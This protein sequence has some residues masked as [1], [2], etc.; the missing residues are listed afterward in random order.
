MVELHSFKSR[1]IIALDPP[2]EISDGLGWALRIVDKTK[3][4]V[5]GYELGLPM[6]IR[7]GGLNNLSKLLDSM[8]DEKLKIADI[9]DMMILSIKP[10]INIGF[11]AFTAHSFTGYNGGLRDLGEYLSRK[12]VLLISIVSMS[13]RG[14][15]ELFDK[16][17]DK[18]VDIAIRSGSWGLVAPATRPWILR[19]LRRLLEARG[20]RHIR[21][22]S[23]GIGAQGGLPGEALRNGAD[24]EV[25]GR[26][27]TRN[28]FPR[29]KALEIVSIHESILKTVERLGCVGHG[30]SK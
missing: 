13:H 28:D 1:L 15:V 12:N 17:M 14:G 5:T 29:R 6:I 30:S 4:L 19:Q 25:I 10:L 26:L 27:I 18:L 24:F 8:G 7:S 11:N 23:P 21:I 9:N 20:W 22:I 3:D 16:L 2:A